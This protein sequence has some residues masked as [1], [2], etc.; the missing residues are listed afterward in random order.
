MLCSGAL[1]EAG[2]CGCVSSSLFSQLPARCLGYGRCASSTVQMYK[3]EIAY[4]FVYSILVETIFISLFKLAQ[5]K[6][7]KKEGVKSL[8]LEN[9]SINV[10][11]GIDENFANM[12][13]F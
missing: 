1:H 10:F 11:L 9:I 7:K 6:Q 8:S 3:W 13:L 4:S 12:Y 5:K 2:A